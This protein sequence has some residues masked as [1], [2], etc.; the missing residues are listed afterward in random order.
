MVYLNHVLNAYSTFSLLPEVRTSVLHDFNIGSFARFHRPEVVISVHDGP[1]FYG[2]SHLDIRL[3]LDRENKDGPFAIIEETTAESHALWYVTTT[4][5]SEIWNNAIDPSPIGYPGEAFTLWHLHI[6]T[7]ALPSEYLEFCYG[8]ADMAEDVT[9]DGTIQYD[10]HN[11]QEPPFGDRSYW[12]K[13]EN[14]EGSLP[15][16]LVIASPGEWQWS[17]DAQLRRK[18]NPSY[19]YYANPAGVV[20]LTSEAA[21]EAGLVASWVWWDKEQPKAGQPVEMRQKV[22]WDSPKWPWDGVTVGSRFQSTI[23]GAA[24][25]GTC[26]KTRRLPLRKPKDHGLRGQRLSNVTASA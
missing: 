16:P 18:A 23:P 2:L 4:E 17:D 26:Q 19:P 11:Q 5:E 15:Q 7:Q 9:V 10:P 13:K 22:D 3:R 8:D 20:K 25:G 14:A 24:K 6:W 12:G 1:D 21:R